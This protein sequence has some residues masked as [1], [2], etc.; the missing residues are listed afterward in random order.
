[1]ARR[2]GIFGG[3]FDPPHIG[4]LAA[5]VHARDQLRLDEVL[6][7]VANDPWQK[8]GDRAITP[9]EDRL[10]MTQAAVGRLEGMAVSAVEIGRGGPSYS[11][12][13]VHELGAPDLDLVLIVGADAAGGLGTWHR[14]AELADAVDVG[15]IRR[16]GS[17][18]AAPAP[19]RAT[20][21]D[22]PLLEVSSSE[23]RRRVRAGGSIDVL[24]PPAVVDYIR[25]RGL[26]PR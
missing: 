26:Y 21:V 16:P 22:M 19:F 7:V 11:I 3:T 5:G 12:D 2:V 18:P 4:H 24:T 8:S 23:L 13:T 25:E 15:I 17:R 1:M 6:F 10:A 20:M 14:A 9:A